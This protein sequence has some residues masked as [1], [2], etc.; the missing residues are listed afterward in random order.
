MPATLT[1]FRS[2]KWTL[3][4]TER[5]STMDKSGC[6]ISHKLHENT[7]FEVVATA[8]D[9]HVIFRTFSSTLSAGYDAAET[10]IALHVATQPK[11]E[12]AA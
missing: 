4:F 8:P 7:A 11:D 9:G 6:A 3:F 5:F 12:V 10:A 1:S 2:A